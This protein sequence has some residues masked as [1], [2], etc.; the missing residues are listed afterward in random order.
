MLTPEDIPQAVIAPVDGL[1][2]GTGGGP[3]SHLAL[4][5]VQTENLARRWDSFPYDTLIGM[6]RDNLG[7][8][9]QAADAWNDLHTRHIFTER[10]TQLRINNLGQALNDLYG[11]FGA[12]VN[13]EE[14]PEGEAQRVR[15]LERIKHLITREEALAGALDAEFITPHMYN[16]NF[17]WRLPS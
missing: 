5:I 9:Y 8:I 15:I 1:R 12:R 11:E 7:W 3:V 16:D 6:E 14:D 10:T 13:R 4:L 2:V 17:T